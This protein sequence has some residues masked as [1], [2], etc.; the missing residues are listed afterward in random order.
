ML[1]R[2]NE[3]DKIFNQHIGAL[4]ENMNK[5]LET[6]TNTFS[7]MTQMYATPY[8]GNNVSSNM[9]PYR[10]SSMQQ[11]PFGA[12]THQ[13]SPPSMIRGFATP[14][15]QSPTRKNGYA[16]ITSTDV[17]YDDGDDDDDDNSCTYYFFK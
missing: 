16:T 17:N 13:P 10:F 11:A 3:Q 5:F 6:M 7:M 15:Q 1:D 8:F 2:M 4:Q 9:P 12:P 14:M